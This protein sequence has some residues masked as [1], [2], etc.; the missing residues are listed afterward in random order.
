MGASRLVHWLFFLAVGVHRQGQGGE[1]DEEGLGEKVVKGLTTDFHH[2]WHRCYFYF[3]DAP[4]PAVGGGD[5]W[6]WDNKGKQATV[7]RVPKETQTSEQASPLS[8]V[9]LSIEYCAYLEVILWWC[10]LIMSVL[11]HGRTTK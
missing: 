7:P 4:V 11:L 9:L 1:E 5:L 10:S 3:Q 6:P 8:P 2:H